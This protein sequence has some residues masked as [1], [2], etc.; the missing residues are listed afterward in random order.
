MTKGNSSALALKE[1]ELTLKKLGALR[2]NL[3]VAKD[4]LPAE[5]WLPQTA[6]IW[7]QSHIE[8]SIEQIAILCVWLDSDKKEEDIR[9]R[10]YFSQFANHESEVAF[11]SLYDLDNA[12]FEIKVDFFATKISYAE[13]SSNLY[14]FW[15]SIE[16]NLQK[17]ITEIKNAIKTHK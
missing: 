10:G 4:C 7:A 3:E 1:L 9:P 17:A 16:D 5:Q 8:D 13:T 11:V 6:L 14:T 12:L 2:A 15:V